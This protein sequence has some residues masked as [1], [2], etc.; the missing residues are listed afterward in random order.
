MYDA[1]KTIELDGW[2][3]EVFQD[4]DPTPPSEWC[5][6]G[7]LAYDTR[8]ASVGEL[9]S[10]P[11]GGGVFTD[12]CDQCGETGYVLDDETGEATSDVC[13]WCSGSGYVTDGHA[14]A[15]H[16]HDSILTLPVYAADYGAGTSLR[17][18]DSWDESNGWIYT[19][20]E[21]SCGCGES[22]ADSAGVIDLEALR[23]NMVA[24]LETWTQWAQGDV[25]AYA[26]TSPDGIVTASCFGFYGLDDAKLEARSALIAELGHD[27]AEAAKI[28]R[29]MAL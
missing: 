16:L 6:V 1:M 8:S 11:Y 7:T 5:S 17:V 12:E 25:Y 3:A 4:P 9:P 10:D 19:T 13:K 28:D 21:C 26:V 18:A 23:L 15:K 22:L 29:M 24:E 20:G 14:I 2:T 27:A